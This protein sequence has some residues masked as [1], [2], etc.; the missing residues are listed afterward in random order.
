[1]KRLSLISLLSIT[2]ATS[3]LASGADDKAHS[4]DTTFLPD[5]A[6]T[7]EVFEASVEHADLEG[8]PKQF[9]T[10]V[11]FCRITL[12]SDQAHIFVFS[13]EGDQPLMAVKPYDLT[14]GFLPF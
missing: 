11:V 2:L 5:G 3:A 13:Y 12:A 8:C 9:D 10:D 14:D 4:G 6:F 1:M 7:Y